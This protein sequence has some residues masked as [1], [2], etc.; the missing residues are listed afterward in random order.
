MFNLV[1]DIQTLGFVLDGGVD[2]AFERTVRDVLDLYEYE[3]FQQLREAFARLRVCENDL[4]VL[5]GDSDPCWM[6][7]WT[8]VSVDP[9]SEN[10]STNETE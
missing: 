4:I 1:Y 2:A 3:I 5:N 9:E 7:K 10:N 8:P 6:D